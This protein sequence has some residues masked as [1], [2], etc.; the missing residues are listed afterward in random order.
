MGDQLTAAQQYVFA[1]LALVIG[2]L[3]GYAASYWKTLGGKKGELQAMHEGIDKLL[4]QV[5]VVTKRQEEIKADIL[6]AV[7]EKQTRWTIKKEVL[8]ETLREMGTVQAA[9]SD[10]A[11]AC[12]VSRENKDPDVRQ[13]NAEMTRDSLVGFRTALYR[14]GAV[15]TLAS[16]VSSDNVRDTLYRLQI[17]YGELAKKSLLDPGPEDNATLATHISQ[18]AEAIRED[19]NAKQSNAA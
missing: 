4:E 18:A 9:Y 1:G 19:L 16:V 10:L 15:R 13:T 14:L 17:L 12:V 7:W 11:G 6:D 5:N 2:L 3:G 8:F